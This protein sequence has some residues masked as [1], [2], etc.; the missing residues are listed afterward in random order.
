MHTKVKS[1]ESL[2]K[3]VNNKSVVHCDFTDIDHSK[4]FM[5]EHLT[6]LYHSPLYTLLN[7]NHKLRYNQLFAL[8]CIEQLMTLEASFI[9]NI[10]NRCINDKSINK[11]EK[12]IYCMTE[13]KAE[14][15]LHYDMFRSLNKKAEP[16]IYCNNDMH[17]ARHS[18]IETLV[19]HG[20][21]KAP[22]ILPFL[23][24]V[25]LIL[26]EFSVF[27]SKQMIT[28][29]DHNKESLEN[30]F[31]TAHREHLKDEARHVHICANILKLLCDKSSSYLLKINAQA[32]KL[33]MKEYITPKHGGLRV[34][35]QLI[36]EFPDLSNIK[37]KL[38]QSIYDTRYKQPICTAISNK[39]SLPVTQAMLNQFPI[40]RI[41]GYRQ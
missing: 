15:I 30:N 18:R 9:S 1:T 23:L 31:V 41:S 12:L 28:H 16:D 21:T 26:E 27:I 20:L 36:K 29:T 40:F 14:E 6:Q 5:H 19:L 24:W 35:D 25:I 2:Y 10:L 33:F 3:L 34:I 8:R 17:F 13:M 22:G 38:N 39:S 4:L 11:N 7:D 32:F 37:S